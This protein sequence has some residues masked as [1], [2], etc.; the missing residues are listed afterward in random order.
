MHCSD[1]S[2]AA[3]KEISILFPQKLPNS[4]SNQTVFNIQTLA[5]LEIENADENIDEFE[6]IVKS[7]ISS[8]NS[9]LLENLNNAEKIVLG[10]HKIIDDQNLEDLDENFEISTNNDMK[11]FKL[12]FVE[13]LSNLDHELLGEK[14]NHLNQELECIS[15]LKDHTN[16]AQKLSHIFGNQEKTLAV[17]KPEAFSRR[18]EI[19]EKIWN[20]GIM[21]EAVREKI[22]TRYL[23]KTY[24]QLLKKG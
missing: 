9:K 15:L 23:K 1:S 12:I 5:V 24:L 16:A 21:I 14:I 4:N 11:H 18:S 10:A 13:I 17:I 8:L 2:E 22:L 3:Q 7:R 6:T 20:N 19:I